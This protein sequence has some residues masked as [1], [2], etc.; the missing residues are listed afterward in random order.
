LIVLASIALSR[1]FACA[2]PFTAL[3]TMAAFTLR[4]QEAL[5]MVLFAWVANQAVG[6]G[7]MHYPWTSSTVCWARR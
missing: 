6:F 3:A 1:A 4:R 5:A 7:L 2:M